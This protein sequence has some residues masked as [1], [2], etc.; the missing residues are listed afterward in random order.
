M[1]SKLWLVLGICSLL[2]IVD[3]ENAFAWGWA[4]TLPAHHT[5]VT[6]R[7]AR[8]HY[9]HGRFY[10]PGP[11]GFF[12]VMPPIGAIVTVLPDGYSTVIVGGISYYSYDSVYYTECPTGYVVVPAPSNVT[13]TQSSPATV[14]TATTTPPGKSITL[15]VPN[16]SGYFTPVKLVKY[17]NGYL[18]PQ[19]EYYPGNPTVDQLSVLYGK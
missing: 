1:K 12:M 19:G 4:R 5:V 18:G 7:G 2:F 8:Y 6:L 11:F 10:R 15:N 13:V 14:T 17:K 16:S 3:A 9:Y